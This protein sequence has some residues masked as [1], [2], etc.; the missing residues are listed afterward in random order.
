LRATGFR[1]VLMVVNY[2]SVDYT[3]P[4]QT[5]FTVAINQTLAEVAAAYGA[6]IAD[7]FSAFQ[8][9]ASTPFAGGKTCMAGLLNASPANQFLCDVHPSQSGQQLIADTVEL[10]YKAALAAH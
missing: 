3:D 10:T 9:A 7:A 8:T 2:Y 5:G 4:V 6:V 1:G